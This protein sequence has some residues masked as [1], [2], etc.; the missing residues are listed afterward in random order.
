MDTTKTITLIDSMNVPAVDI[1]TMVD[2][3]TTVIIVHMM[4]LTG[5]TK[6]FHIIFNHYEDKKIINN[7]CAIFCAVLNM[8]IN[9][10]S[11][12]KL[13]IRNII[14]LSHFITCD[15]LYLFCAINWLVNLL[16][17]YYCLYLSMTCVWC[18]QNH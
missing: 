11:I 4:K 8:L 6:N 10:I 2:I 7:I 9:V 17:H 16:Y 12:Q 14:N 5:K 15:L 13:S 1:E 3:M 18:T